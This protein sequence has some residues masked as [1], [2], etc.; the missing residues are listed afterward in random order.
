MTSRRAAFAG[1]VPRGAPA[2]LV[3]LLV[4]ILPR[5]ASAQQSAWRFDQDVQLTY[6]FDDNVEE[7]LTD[8]PLQAQVARLTYRGDVRWGGGRE[9]LTVSYQAGSSAI[10]T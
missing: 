5:A 10:S 4:L 1:P 3:V 8:D 7:E 6:E 9:R 2:I